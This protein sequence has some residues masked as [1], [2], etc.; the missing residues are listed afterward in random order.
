MRL[1][2]DFGGHAGWAAARRDVAV[3]L[4]ENWELGFSMRGESA[5]ND[6]E[7][8]LIDASGEN[9]WW[10]VRRDFTPSSSWTRLV[11]KKRHFSFA[12]GP[13]GGGE[14]RQASALEITVTARAGGRGWIAIEALTITPLPAPGPPAHPP[15]LTASS[16]A[17]GYGPERAMD[18]D[19]A[20]S[21]RSAGADPAWL[22]IDLGERREFGGMT[23]E[24]EPGRFAGRYRVETSDDQRKWTTAR[25]VEEGNGGRDDLFLPESE[26]RYLRLTMPVAGTREGPGIREIVVQPLSYSAS[27]NAFF[28]AIARDAPRGAYPRSFSGE[29]SYWTVAGADGDTENALVGED[30]AVEPAR[31][32]F[33]VEPFLFLDGKLLS[34]SDVTIE[35]G[36]EQGDLPIPTV[37]W[38][39]GTLRLTITAFVFGPPGASSLQVRYRVGNSGAGRRKGKLFLA[40]RPFQVNPPTQFLNGAGG[41]TK[42]ASLEWDGSAVSVDGIPRVF[43]RVPPA[44]FGAV[45]FDG[46]PITDFLARGKLPPSTGA[47][48]GAGYASGVLAFDLD[49]PPGGADEVSLELPLHPKTP[50]DFPVRTLTRTEARELFARRLASCA[51]EWRGKVDRVELA[52]PAAARPLLRTLR[53]NLAYALLERDGPA[54]RPGTRAYARSWIRDG[55]LICAALLRLGHADAARAYIEWFAKFQDPDGRVPC[56]VDSRGADAVAE[57]D[58]HGELLFAIAEYWRFT[59]DGEFLRR[60]FPHVESAVAYI[61]SLRQKRRTE[62][63]RTPEKLPFFGLLP[64]SISHEGYS[65]KPVHSY[66]DDFWALKGLKDATDLAAAGDRE[67]L[68]SRWAALRDEFAKDLFASLSRTISS[69]GIDFIPGSAE[70]ADFD[71]TA[72]TIA[73]DP[74]GELE[75]LPRRQLLR[76][77]ERYDEE[78]LRRRDGQT[79]WDAYTPYEIRTVGA[80]VRLDW[81]SRTHALLDFFLSGRRPAAW[82]QWA[83][84]LG[85]EPRA[86]R[87]V[88]DMPHAWVGADFI[89]SCLDL[90]A[91][92]RESDGALVLAAGIPAGWLREGPGVAV[93]RLRTPHGLLEYTLRNEK[94][95]LRFTIGDLAIPP[96][97]IAL[98]PPLESPPRRVTVNGKS[99]PFTGEELVLHR[100]PADVLF[101]R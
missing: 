72:T 51:R 99:V 80:F 29:Q 32:S 38:R 67:D 52:G 78:F 69:R 13:A 70:L 49:P 34:W 93:R 53:S 37:A 85:R 40:L 22:E 89:R 84:V 19:P 56:C 62:E 4:P 98:R 25:A 50:P 55:A 60:V 86:P 83:E 87:F 100:L 48:D 15:V 74:A 6:L 8:K 44:G 36:L 1:D 23:I 24:W 30:G 59:R 95:G 2:F 91:F 71:P 57:N 20:S 9:V 21:W 18:G 27:P 26:S 41:A 88:G 64:E 5:P 46:G 77:F 96:G 16:S 66:W 35:H 58:S 61:D 79:P 68:R 65:A 92:E 11:S 63:Y 101:E 10:A 54:I 17:P 3:D 31:G 97:G 43:A 12:W 28:E 7:V 76:T 42:I 75:R 47:R 73:L 94:R 39:H 45:S 90:L 81:R 14:I 33:S 82:N